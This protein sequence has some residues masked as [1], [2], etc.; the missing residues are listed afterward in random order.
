MSKKVLVVDDEPDAQAFVAS[1]LGDDYTVT[2]AGS[3][4]DGLA[5]ARADTPDLMILDVQMPGKDGFVLFDE[6]GHDDALKNVP[7]IMLTGIA[8]KTGMKFS[9]ED[10]NEFIGR[11]P[12]AYL[13]KP[14]DPDALAKTVAEVLE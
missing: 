1:V 2:T 14:I 6:L 11:S 10:M 12:V 7:V 9:A 5:Q 3:A 8:E 13:E 4:D